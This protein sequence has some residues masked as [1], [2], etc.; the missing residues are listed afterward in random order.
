MK[1]PN[2]K[3]KYSRGLGDLV[4]CFL[5]SKL[6]GWITKIITKK[7][8][9]C[10]QCAVRVNALNIIFPIPFWRL[11]FKNTEDLL[12]SLKKEL[13]DFGYTVNFT[14]DKL[15]LNSFKSEENVELKNEEEIKKTD[16]VDISDTNNYKFLSS[17]DTML[18]DFLIKTEIYKRK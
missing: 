9:P 18:G 1:D 8:E 7:T 5:H 17:G 13:E 12:K 16:D 14:N 3:I 4:A 11:F 10:Q 15:G 6:I 2:L